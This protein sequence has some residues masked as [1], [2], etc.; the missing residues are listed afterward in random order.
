MERVDLQDLFNLSKTCKMFNSILH[1]VSARSVWKLARLN[2]LLFKH[3]RI[4]IPPSGVA[5]S[6]WAALLL[7]RRR[8]WV[9][10]GVCVLR[11]LTN[12][13][14]RTVTLPVML[15]ISFSPNCVV[16]APAV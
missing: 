10:N 13:H 16:C 4:P 1:D 5:E 15:V 7:G 9:R 2:T 12:G 6:H 8:C 3:L 14:V 11:T